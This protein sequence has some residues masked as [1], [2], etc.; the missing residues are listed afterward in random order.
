VGIVRFAEYRQYE[1]VR[2]EAN[3]AIMGLL[4]GAQMAAHMLQ[5]T[6]GSHRLLP[7]IFPQI[8]HIGRFSL[9]T[10]S[11]RAI[12]EA[13][14]THLGAM[15][16]PYAL[17]IH[18]DYLK[19][20]LTLLQRGGKTLSRPAEELNLASQ[21]EEIERATGRSFNHTSIQQIQVLRI[22]RNC[23]IHS[24]GR[25]D[26]RLV[27]RLARYW[28]DEAESGWLRL[29]KVSPSALALGDPLLFRSGEALIAL[30][31]TKNLARE[32]TEFLAAALPRGLW[33]ELLIEDLV[34]ETPKIISD[35][36]ALRKARSLARWHYS[37]LKLTVDEISAALS[38]SIANPQPTVA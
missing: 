5:L 18:E 31:I 27:N 32:A 20:C 21:H 22:M 23:T 2:V 8:P 3:N 29:A 25:V 35:P 17:A 37:P 30:A 34:S 24:G 15:A 6:E 4:S 38:R 16:V 11:A 19:T 33:A 14:D 9:K 36:N 7:E 10:E 13:G 26:R 28:S 12:L 1:Q